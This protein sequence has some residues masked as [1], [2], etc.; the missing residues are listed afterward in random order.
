MK[1]LLLIAVLIL[2]LLSSCFNV[3]LSDDLEAD[4]ANLDER[5]KNTRITVNEYSGGLLSVLTSIRL[6][7]LMTTKSMLEQKKLGLKRFIPISYTVDGKKYVP[8]SDKDTL[9]QNIERDLTDLRKHLAEAKSEN[10]RYG[11][12]LL[13]VL[14]LTN[15]ATIKNSITFLEQRKLL[16]KHDI[17]Y[18]SLLPKEEDKGPGFEPT[19]GDDVDK[20]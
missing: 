16:L 17:P 18:Y 6:E 8:P 7:T 14:S 3:P 20:F 1:Y 2:S 15:T 19:S 13:G 4:I 5:V 11:R 12:G 10:E 9:L